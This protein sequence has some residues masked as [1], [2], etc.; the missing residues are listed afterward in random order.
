MGSEA[1]A[2]AINSATSITMDGSI[3]I[4]P[5]SAVPIAAARFTVCTAIVGSGNPTDLGMFL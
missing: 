5:V 1:E 3:R 4:T 2:F